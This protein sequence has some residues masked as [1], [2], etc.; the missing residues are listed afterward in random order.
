[1]NGVWKVKK[2]ILKYVLGKGS[3][4]NSGYFPDGGGVHPHSRYFFRREILKSAYNG[5]IHPEN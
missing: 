1:M 3:L 4:K 2:N 5:L